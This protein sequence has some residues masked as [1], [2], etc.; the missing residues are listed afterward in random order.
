MGDNVG[1]RPRAR[2]DVVELAT[3]IGKDSIAA[4][5]RFLDACEA[6]FEL[7]AESPRIGGIHLTKNRRL[8]DL[9]V[10]RVRGFPNHLAF[11]LERISGIEIVR[12]VHGLRD[13][14]AV[15]QDE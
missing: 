13:L 5:N 9:R 6:T 4:A 7:L 11:Y 10:F 3:Y 1:I 8:A 12:V 15:L 14:D 2:L